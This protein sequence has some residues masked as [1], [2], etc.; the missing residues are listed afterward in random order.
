MDALARVDAWTGRVA[1]AA[2]KER[3]RAQ[4]EN[5][6]VDQYVKAVSE[7]IRAEQTAT[8]RKRFD[9]DYGTGAEDLWQPHPRLSSWATQSTPGTCGG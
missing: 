4:A 9:E 7:V 6:V 2:A 1:A 3:E 5:A 8:A